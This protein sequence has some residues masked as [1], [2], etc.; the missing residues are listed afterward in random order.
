MKNK[1]LNA[2]TEAIKKQS[3][4]INR[5]ENNQDRWNAQDLLGS[6]VNKITMNLSG[7]EAELI[8]KS[9]LTRD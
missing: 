4:E 7:D 6:I 2:I 1:Y 9:V 3:F 5:I 8:R